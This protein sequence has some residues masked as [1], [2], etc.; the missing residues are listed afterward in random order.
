MVY[1]CCMINRLLEQK[2]LTHWTDQKALII[3]G[4]RQ[5]GK[6]TLIEKM[7]S[8]EDYLWLSGDEY[9]V[10]EKLS[11]ANAESLRSLIGN[12]KFIVID[13]AQRIEN[14]GLAI[15]IIIDQL[16]D[17]KVIVSGSSALELANKIN[18]PL[19]GRKWEF[20]LYPFSFKE[21]VNHHGLLKETRNLEPRLIYGYYPDV[22]NN[23]GQEKE[24]L[25]NLAISYLYRDIF[26]IDSIKYPDKI[27]LLLKALAFQIGQQ[28]SYNELSKYCKMDIATVEKYIHLLEKAFVLFRVPSFHRNIRNELKKSRKIYFYDNGIRNALIDQFQGINS[29]ADTGALWE[30]FLMSERLKYHK[31]ANKTVNMYFWRTTAQQEID[32]IEEENG[33]IRCYEFKWNPLKKAIITKTFTAQYQPS[34]TE[35]IHSE[36]FEGFLL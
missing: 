35:V 1:I 34:V 12:R 13:E 22:V 14:I 4:P 28:V 5:V 2:I 3:I 18:E 11:K 9:D 6:T 16:K 17:V 7:V 30:N 27:E 31:Y 15:K 26:T 20:N 8:G 19:T 21:M 24:I 33:E 23:P 29:R 32:L 25:K 36:N 10:R